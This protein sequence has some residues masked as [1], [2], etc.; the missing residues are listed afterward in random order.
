MPN[1]T[2]AENE[3]SA[4]LQEHFPG[5]SATAHVEAYIYNHTDNSVGSGIRYQVAVQY[6]PESAGV[7]EIGDGNTLAVAIAE[8]KSKRSEKI[9][10]PPPQKIVEALS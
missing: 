2:N 8:V 10:K 7:W 4:C 9:G 6:K 3:L 1:M 5:Y